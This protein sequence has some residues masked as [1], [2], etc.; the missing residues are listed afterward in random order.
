MLVFVSVCQCVL[1]NVSACLLNFEYFQ[2]LLKD[3]LGEALARQAPMPNT[4]PPLP[5]TPMEATPSGSNQNSSSSSSPPLPTNPSHA[6]PTR[7]FLGGLHHHVT[8]HMLEAH[9]RKYGSI[10]KIE[11][12][13]DR[14]TG[15]K[16]GFAFLEYFVS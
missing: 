14:A 2:T 12:P 13:K 10:S 4:A 16:R 5:P 3:V 6:S 9:F 7:L 15:A 1:V 8:E 11:I